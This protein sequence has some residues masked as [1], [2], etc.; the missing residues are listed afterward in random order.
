MINYTTSEKLKGLLAAVHVRGDSRLNAESHL[1]ELTSLAETGGIEAAVTK[2]VSISSVHSNLFIGK[3]QAEEITEEARQK[4]IEVIIFDEDLSPSQQRNWE[5]LT[6]IR[7]IDRREL[8]LDIF[9]ARASTKEAMLQ[10]ELA[11]YEYMLP[12]LN[13]AWTHLS[14][15]QGGERGTRGEGEK[16]IELDRR[17]ILSRIHAIKHEIGLVETQRNLRR[18]NR[19]KGNIPSASIIG[20][21]NAGKSSLLN[22]LTS[23]GVLTENKLFATLD[24]TTRKYILPDKTKLLLTDTVGFIRKLPHDLVEAFHST[25]EESVY[26]DFLIHV[27]D[28]AAS[29]VEEHA[30]ATEKVL[31]SLGIGDK[32]RLTVFNKTDLIP[33][34]ITKVLLMNRYPDA[35]FL[36]LKTKE[37]MDDLLS[38]LQQFARPLQT[39][40]MFTLPADRHDLVAFLHRNGE[41]MHKDYGDGEISVSARVSPKIRNKLEEYAV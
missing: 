35:V 12:R 36:S 4:Q 28:A 33:D 32:P 6:G 29:E 31:S 30:A 11:Q 15:Q 26:S 38:Q 39:M 37:G 2:I 21:T 40:E 24:P 41:V 23:A 16:Q 27:V 9:A 3:G 7:V 17:S 34:Q 22:Y 10:I 20:Y 1:E 25:L 8:I 14:R 19:M 5:R 18:K 13:R